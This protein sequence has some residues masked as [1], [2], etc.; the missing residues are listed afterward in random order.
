MGSAVRHR[1]GRLEIPMANAFRGMFLNLTSLAAHIGR[2]APA[3]RILE[4]GC[5]DGLFAQRLAAVYP[6]AR[7]LGIDVVD[8]AGRLFRGDPRWATFRNITVQ[9]LHAETPEPFDLVLF[10]DVLHHVPLDI[11]TEVLRSAAELVR[12]GGH[13][14]V[15]EFERNRGPYY[16]L[17]FAA[18]R[19]LSGDRDVRFMTL[20]ELTEMVGTTSGYG[21][22]DLRVAR[23]GPARN[24]IV[25]VMR[26][27]PRRPG[28]SDTTRLPRP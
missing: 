28:S 4:V 22:G 16:H 23:I 25:F 13:L 27:I 1:L 10:A 7:Y 26:R 12:P 17:T 6:Q 20:P 11:R 5:G 8:S 21:F 15:K 2:A 3:Q 18:D 14:V 9:D 19:Y 24:N